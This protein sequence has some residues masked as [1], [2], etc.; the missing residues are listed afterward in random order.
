MRIGI[1]IDDTTL[2]TV[3]FMIKYGDKFSKEDLGKKDTKNNLGKIKNRYYLNS[4]YGWTDEEKFS[5]FDKYY[6]N[7]LEECIPLPDAPSIIRKLKEEGDEIYFISARITSIKG[8]ETEKITKNTFSTYGIPYDR[9]I[10]AAYDKCQYCLENQISIFIDDSYEVL[11]EL[12][13]KGIRCFLMTTPMNAD[14]EVEKEIKRVKSWKEIYKKI[15]EDL[16]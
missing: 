10:I 5:F 4:L 13:S 8:C 16:K 2:N 11:K 6:K 15:K 14:I 7:V 1:D 12:S 3:T 9:L